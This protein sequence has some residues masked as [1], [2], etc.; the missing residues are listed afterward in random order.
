MVIL[1][2]QLFVCLHYGI[3]DEFIHLLNLFRR[4][5]RLT[6]R[7]RNLIQIT[8]YK[9]SKNQTGKLILII[10]TTN[11]IFL[12]QNS[13]SLYL[14]FYPLMFLLFFFLFKFILFY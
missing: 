6:V 13:V 10:F 9:L 14:S 4:L 8:H 7:A 12:F 11:S 1:R 3:Y 5:S 2:T